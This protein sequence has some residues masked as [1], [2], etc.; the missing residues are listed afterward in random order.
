MYEVVDFVNTIE[1]HFS[2]KFTR[3]FMRL[4]GMWH[5]ENLYD[6]LISNMVLFY[7][8]TT[9]IIAII[10]E[11][12]DCYYCWGDLHAF[13]YNVP[14][15]ITV[16]LELFKLTKFLINRSEVMSFN[17]FTENTF[18]KNNYE[19]A[20]LT[21]LNNCD[22]QCIKIVAIYFFVLQSICWQYLTVPIF[23]SIGKNSSDRTLP[24]NLWFNFP[25]KETPYYEIA[26]TL[27]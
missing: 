21:I 2:I 8:F 16:L 11:G 22:S 3:F 5:N 27:Q 12:F 15:T 13:S 20:D 17:A 14:C 24:F 7:T 26:F 10:V 23:E 4:V 19:E 9:M 1:N 25:F 6:Q 18:W